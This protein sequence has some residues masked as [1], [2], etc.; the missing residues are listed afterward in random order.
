M[1]YI[2][3]NPYELYHHGIKGQKWGV[4]RYQ[5]EDGTL[6]RAGQLRLETKAAKKDARR[7]SWDYSHAINRDSLTGGIFKGERGARAAAGEKFREK[8]K[9]YLQ[10]KNEYKY[11]KAKEKGKSETKLEKI[12]NKGAEKEAVFDAR[13]KVN[14]AIE[15]AYAQQ[16]SG[17]QIV[18]NIMASRGYNTGITSKTSVAALESVGYTKDGARIVSILLGESNSINLAY[19]TATRDAKREFR[20]NLK[21]SE[22]EKDKKDDD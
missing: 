15:D 9:T 5:N 1:I 7:A 19:R 14:K 17:R 20:D 16:S 12:K 22:E 18:Q 4:R 13:S 6:T 8:A 11:E 10:T 3:C 2:Y 21:R